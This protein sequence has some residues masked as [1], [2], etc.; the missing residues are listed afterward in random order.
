MRLTWLAYLLSVCDYH[1]ISY[2]DITLLSM[3]SHLLYTKMPHVRH[4]ARPLAGRLWIPS[5]YS[6][7]HHTT[8]HGITLRTLHNTT[9]EC[10][11]CVI[12]LAHSLGVCENFY[13]N[14]H[15]STLLSMTSHCKHYIT[16]YENVM[17]AS[18]GLPIHWVYVITITLLILALLNIH[19]H[20]TK[21]G[22]SQQ[23]SSH[24]WAWQY[25]ATTSHY[26][27]RRYS[28]ITITLAIHYWAN[29]YYIHC[30]TDL[31]CT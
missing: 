31:K 11:I 25:S 5:H 30:I 13:I 27:A 21:H 14:Y 15:D 1:H 6:P 19:Q 2:H 16:L 29:W 4:Q 9:L 10:H 22:N 18:P 26:W 8:E 23:L 24:Y 12:R 17:Q 3:A 7:W 28:A 20:L